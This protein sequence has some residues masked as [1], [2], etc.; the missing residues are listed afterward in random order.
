MSD[1]L[2][3]IRYAPLT[4][5]LVHVRL[6]FE[7]S[8]TIQQPTSV[9]YSSMEAVEEMTIDLTLDPNAFLHVVSNAAV[10]IAMHSGT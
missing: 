6:S 5:R 7:N 1:V 3:Q 8:S 10:Y 2:T 4:Q 9:S